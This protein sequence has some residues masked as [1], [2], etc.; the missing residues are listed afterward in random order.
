MTTLGK[1]VGIGSEVTLKFSEK[2]G[3][4]EITR[5]SAPSNIV[6]EYRGKDGEKANKT[7]Y[8]VLSEELQYVLQELSPNV[9]N[10]SLDRTERRINE[11][12][13][14]RLNLTEAQ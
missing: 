2:S 1:Y 13:N 8:A 9:K 10:T 14:L 5:T 11:V 6:L 4:Y 7:F 12:K 3:I